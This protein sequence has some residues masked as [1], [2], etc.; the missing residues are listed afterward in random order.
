MA[1]IR[2][3]RQR[4]AEL[5]SLFGVH[6]KTVKAARTGATWRHIRYELPELAAE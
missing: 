6:K 2:A 4:D 5:A 3:S 1:E